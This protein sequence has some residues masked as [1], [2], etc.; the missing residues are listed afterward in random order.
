MDNIAYAAA[1][2]YTAD[3]ADRLGSLKGAPCTVSKIVDVTDTDGRKGKR[4]TLQWTGNSGATQT[5]DF[6]IYGGLNGKDGRDAEDIDKATLK[7]LIEDYLKSNPIRANI[8][9]ISVNGTAITPDS[10]KNANIIVPDVSGL[11]KK[12]EIPDVSTF[13]SETDIDNKI[14]TATTDME[15]K[16]DVAAKLG[17]YVKTDDLPQEKTKLSEFINDSGFLT[18]HQSLTDYAKLTDLQN[19]VKVIR[20]LDG[21]DLNNF[22][23]PGIYHFWG[24][25]NKF[26]NA[27]SE[28][29][30][31]GF[32]TLLVGAINLNYIYQACVLFSSN[33]AMKVY[34]RARRG[35]TASWS[36]WVLEYFSQG[37][38]GNEKVTDYT[39]QIV[40]NS[41]LT[42]TNGSFSLIKCGRLVQFQFNDVTITNLK[43]NVPI[44]TLPQECRPSVNT[45]IIVGMPPSSAA[46][47]AGLTVTTDWTVITGAIT[48]GGNVVLYSTSNGADV[49]LST[50][51]MSVTFISAD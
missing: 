24:S 12:T 22:T 46:A 17:D 13:V 41:D 23:E 51:K 47:T 50:G 4:I 20:A 43:H 36:D 21:T 33:S 2:K 35:A 45:R 14:A 1:K 42:I 15:T 32:V 25:S 49:R 7:K 11:A 30:S 3:T 19:R 26:S 44:C 31:Y 34:Y 9:S 27:P 16:T 6:E 39:S 10:N 48:I 5:Q 38:N 29:V 40:N 8:D 37:S 18:A 28:T